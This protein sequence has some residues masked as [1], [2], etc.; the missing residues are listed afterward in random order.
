M[1][2][3]TKGKCFFNLQNECFDDGYTTRLHVKS[4]NAK[5]NSQRSCL[6]T[7]RLFMVHRIRTVD[8]APFFGFLFPC[9]S[10]PITGVVVVSFWMVGEDT[11]SSLSSSLLQFS[12]I[13]SI[14]HNS[15]KDKMKFILLSLQLA[16]AFAFSGQSQ[17][18]L[19]SHGV[20]R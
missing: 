15:F 20:G 9:Q 8:G 19:R 5:V 10:S 7:A 17:F 12:E 18:A 3:L 14:K 13:A 2:I 4:K 11:P 1:V 16:A 6:A